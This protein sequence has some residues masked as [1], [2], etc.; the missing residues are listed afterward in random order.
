[1]IREANTINN[2]PFYN[3]Y[4]LSS[5]SNNVYAR[6]IFYIEENKI[7][8]YLIYEDIYDRFEID[9]IYVE[10][11]Y[12]KK[13]VASKMLDAL[14]H[15]ANEKKVLNITLEVKKDNHNAI[16]LYLKFGFISKA[17]RRGYYNGI[18][19]ILMEKEMM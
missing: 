14:I 19:G 8:G 15:N 9:Y 4:D 2:L 13:G 10:D 16:A 6:Y 11:N 3:P 1:M 5:Y 17:I 7:V 18:D 12:R